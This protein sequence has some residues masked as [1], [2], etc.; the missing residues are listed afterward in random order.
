MEESMVIS[1]RR[2]SKERRDGDQAHFPKDDRRKER[3]GSERRTKDRIPV[4][5]WIRNIDGEAS[6]FQQTGNL[7]T[8]GMYI[9]SPAP[10]EKGTRITLEFQIPASTRVVR[11]TA[12]VVN[13]RAD[14]QFWGVSVK[15]IDVSKQDKAEIEKAVSNLLSEYWYLVE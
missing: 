3:R 9:L 7:S 12:E 8:S 1:G 13:C 4:K 5:M 14:G 11:C 10:H 2:T 6:Y 15:F